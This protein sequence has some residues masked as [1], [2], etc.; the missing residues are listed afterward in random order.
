MVDETPGGIIS[1]MVLGRGP[2][3][4]SSALMILRSAQLKR[5]LHAPFYF[6]HKLTEGARAGD[7]HLTRNARWRV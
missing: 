5:L 6:M 7:A 4:E 2:P 1:P 3:H